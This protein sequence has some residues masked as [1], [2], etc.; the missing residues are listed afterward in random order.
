MYFKFVLH[1]V[2]IVLYKQTRK[3]ISLKKNEARLLYD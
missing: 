3:C 2:Y 1:I